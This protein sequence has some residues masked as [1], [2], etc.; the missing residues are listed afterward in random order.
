[1]VVAIPTLMFYRYFQGR[2][3]TLVISMEKETMRLLEFLQEGQQQ[4]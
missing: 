1:L 4:G 3:E 2:V